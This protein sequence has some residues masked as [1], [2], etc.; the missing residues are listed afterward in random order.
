MRNSVTGNV[1]EATGFLHRYTHV[2]VE[3]YSP[4]IGPY[5]LALAF[6]PLITGQVVLAHD[7]SD[8]VVALYIRS[9]ARHNSIA[10]AVELI[11]QVIVLAILGWLAFKIS[12]KALCRGLP[13]D[14]SPSRL[15][16]TRN[17]TDLS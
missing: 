3:P 2:L 12:G 15:G 7:G 10:V 17:I 8:S 11:S 1:S 9:K 16:T 6:S 5:R 13:K 14:E 4:G